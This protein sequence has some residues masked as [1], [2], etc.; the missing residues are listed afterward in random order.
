[1][2]VARFLDGTLDFMGIPRLL[3]AA[4]TRYGEGVDQAPG[5]DDLV[6]LDH[7]VRAAFA[8]GTVGGLA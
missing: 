1:V 3:E 4:V 2:A 5:V 8:T 6:A 7:E